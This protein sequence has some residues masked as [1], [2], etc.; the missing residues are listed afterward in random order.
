[1]YVC[2]IRYTFKD[3]PSPLSMK[4]GR[5]CSIA[6]CK[7]GI[8]LFKWLNWDWHCDLSLVVTH[9]GVEE[10]RQTVGGYSSLVSKVGA[11]FPV[12]IYVWF[13]GWLIFLWNMDH[14]IWNMKFFGWLAFGTWIWN[15]VLEYDF[16]TWNMVLERDFWIWNIVLEHDFGIWTT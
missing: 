2:N 13:V 8:H 11:P 4:P 14:G 7:P 6:V 3:L 10:A 16:G 1:M 9:Q 15:M 5:Y 12:G